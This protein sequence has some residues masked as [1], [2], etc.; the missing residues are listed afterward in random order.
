[1]PM[2]GRPSK[3]TMSRPSVSAFSTPEETPQAKSPLG[4]S[5]QRPF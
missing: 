5:E 2:S 4:Q 3:N 1:M